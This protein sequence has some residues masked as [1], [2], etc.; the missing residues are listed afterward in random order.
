MDRRKEN[1]PFDCAQMPEVAA[2]IATEKYLPGFSVEELNSIRQAIIE[3]EGSPD[4][5]GMTC[6]AKKDY[7]FV[8]NKILRGIE[9]GRMIGYWNYGCRDKLKGVLRNLNRHCTECTA[10][11]I[12]RVNLTRAQLRKISQ[13]QYTTSRRAKIS[14]P[15][16]DEATA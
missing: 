12:D 2:A 6:I 14:L 8:A 9:G 11:C 3:I 13:E 10:D 4:D 7:Q 15:V 16:L 5:G 1:G